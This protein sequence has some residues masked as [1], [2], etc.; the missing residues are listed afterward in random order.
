MNKL[1]SLNINQLVQCYKT[2]SI[3][4]KDV[5]KICLDLANKYKH[6]NCLVS[7]CSEQAEEKARQS[8]ERWQKERA[9]GELDGVPIAIKDNFCVKGLPTTCASRMLENFVP[10]YNATPFDRLDDAGAVLIGKTNLDEFSMGSG[11]VD[12]I[13]GPTKNVWRS[14]EGHIAGGSSGGSAV[15]VATGSCFAALGSDTGGS[16]RNPAS[17]C[18][19]IGLKPTYGLVSRHG[20]IPLVNSMD[21]PAI[22]SRSVDDCVAILNAIAGPDSKDATCIRKHYSPIEIPKADDISM[23]NI[24]IGIPREY[25]C[26]GLSKDVLDTWIKVADILEDSGANVV[27]VSLPNTESSIFVYTILNQ[28]EVSSNMARYDGIE[29]GYRTKEWSSTEQF[30]AINRQIGFNSVIKNR[31]LCGN[32]FLLSKN[33]DR[34][35]LKALKVRRAI[36]NDFER[37]FHNKD[38]KQN[39]DLILTPTTLSDAPLFTEFTQNSNRDQCAVQDF[40]T[41]AANM[42]GIPAVAIPIRLSDRKLPLSLQLMGPKNSE[43]QLL[44]TAKWIENQ[45]NFPFFQFLQEK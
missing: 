21:V 36:S 20:L 14:D 44:T 7:V 43:K 8:S 28:S 41:Q 45:V 26:N 17:Y 27:E 32:Y 22:L 30:F 16:V 23:K 37:V 10:S 13:F 25:H 40:C 34:Y 6:L 29:Y 5:T 24:R 15:A 12:S 18:G 39:V 2:K 42:A 19:L 3:D 4:P 38:K 35:Y 11:A 31:I 33:Y 9:I 1:V